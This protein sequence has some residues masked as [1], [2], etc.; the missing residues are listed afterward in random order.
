MHYAESCSADEADESGIEEDD[1]KTGSGPEDS[2]ADGS[3][4]EGSVCGSDVVDD[5]SCEDSESEGDEEVEEDDDESVAGSSSSSEFEVQGA[6]FSDARGPAH[7]ELAAAVPRSYSAA[8]LRMMRK[9]FPDPFPVAVKLAANMF[10]LPSCFRDS[11]GAWFKLDMLGAARKQ[12]LFLARIEGRDESLGEYAALAL[13]ALR[14]APRLP[15]DWEGPLVVVVDVGDSCVV[16]SRVGV[17]I[18]LCYR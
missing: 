18:F 17:S 7:H 8:D 6:D 16:A 12:C 11:S 15:D 1:E 4:V 2:G 10:G 5:E 3:A 13:D 14:D 9:K